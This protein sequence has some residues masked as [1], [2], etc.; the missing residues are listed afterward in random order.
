M[1]LLG[2]RGFASGPA[3]LPGGMPVFAMPVRNPAMDA[4]GHF[5][6]FYDCAHDTGFQGAFVE[7]PP[8]GW[9]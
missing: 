8:L 9:R 1:E 7:F 6:T 3:T 2:W 4:A 5:V